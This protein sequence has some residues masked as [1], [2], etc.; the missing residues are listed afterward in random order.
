MA[1]GEDLTDG[2]VTE[3]DNSE[4]VTNDSNDNNDE[5][6]KEG[7]VTYKH[8]MDRFVFQKDLSLIFV[9]TSILN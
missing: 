7:I 3:D 4:E 5:D 1:S 2:I 8:Y 9:S 6:S